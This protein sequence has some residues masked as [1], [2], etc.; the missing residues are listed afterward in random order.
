M[1]RTWTIIGVSARLGAVY[2][3][4]SADRGSLRA[5]E[6]T[7]RHFGRSS[8]VL[9]SQVE[10]QE[11]LGV[12]LSQMITLGPCASVLERCQDPSKK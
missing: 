4:L 6:K 11:V 5:L 7:C 1:K 2:P 10:L 12:Q 8:I 3:W 9:D